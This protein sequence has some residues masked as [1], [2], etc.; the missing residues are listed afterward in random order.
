MEMRKIL[1]APD[2]FKGSVSSEEV[3]RQMGRAVKEVNP[4]IDVVTLPMA[5][6][7]EGTVDALLYARG[8]E[9]MKV[10][11]VDPLGRPIEASYGLFPKEKLAVIETAAASGLPLLNVN[12]LD[13]Y[14]ATT[15]GTGLLIDSAIQE[16][17]KTIMLGLGGSATV[18]A[19]VGLLQALG[20]KI[21]DEND[22]ELSI[23]GGAL[24]QIK[25]INTELL[26][27]RIKH[28][29]FIVASDVTNPLL[30]RDGANYTFG[31][32]KGLTEDTLPL[33]EKGMEQ[34]ANIVVAHTGVDHRF[35][36]GAGAAGG[37]GYTAYSLLNAEFRSGIDLVMEWSNFDEH[38]KGA[39][40]VF[41]G[42]G[43]IDGQTLFG[44]VPVGIARAAKKYDVPTIA[45]AGSVGE[46]VEKLE[47]E[48]I[49]MTM[50]IVDQPMSLEKAMEQGAD[51]IYK[52]TKRV[53]KLISL[54]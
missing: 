10:K 30:G 45:F 50:P 47:S 26:Q 19:G 37:I 1:V 38:V 5:D 23:V 33:F 22:Q 17:A 36:E 28:V 51:L 52:Q 27:E 46:G 25:R 18:D 7:G 6:G 53:I 34:F 4:A 16:G 32:Q 31:P 35:H 43:K 15:Y 41:T 12:E 40:F 42:E 3:A 2:S 21:Y 48:G 8:G 44:K 54:R 14:R 29:Q 9:R 39:D 24:E 49:V 11:S 13:P 20:V